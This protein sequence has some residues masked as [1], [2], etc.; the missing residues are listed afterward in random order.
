MMK[1][2]HLFNIIILKDIVLVLI[3][4]K[5]YQNTPW[6]TKRIGH[7]AAN[8]GIF[9]THRI[10]FQS[11]I[12]ITAL[13]PTTTSFWYIVHGVENYPIILGDLQLPTN[14]K[15]R[16]YKLE[17]IELTPLQFITLATVNNSAGALYQVFLQASS[18]DYTYLEACYR[19]KI[20]NN[21]NYM[22]LSSGTEDFYLSS[23]YFD[24]GVYHNDNAGCTYFNS[25]GSVS[26]YKFFE[27]DPILFTKH[28]ELV[29]RC[30]EVIGNS[31]SDCPNTFTRNDTVMQTEISDKNGHKN[32]NLKF[33]DVIMTSYV[34]IYEYSFS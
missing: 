20:D 34:W 23:Y 32:S 33:S 17:N 3:H 8:G 14:T 19:I 7:N 6:A 27:S 18:S 25:N 21:E 4:Q 9:N 29:W 22:F 2:Y 31:S 10:P 12:R 1:L 13:N 26:A 16:L 28:M 11:T 24:D 15:L 30:G 5:K